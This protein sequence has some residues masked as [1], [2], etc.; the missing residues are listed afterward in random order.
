MTHKTRLNLLIVSYITIL[1]QKSALHY[2]LHKACRILS[3]IKRVEYMQG[4][5]NNQESNYSCILSSTI[6]KFPTA[7]YCKNKLR[8]TPRIY[9]IL[10]KYL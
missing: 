10:P 2:S 4:V 6:E 5:S 3:K 9:R 1:Q 7:E 8:Y